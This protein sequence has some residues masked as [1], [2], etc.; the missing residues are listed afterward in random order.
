MNRFATIDPNPYPGFVPVKNGSSYYT[1]APDVPR[2]E[3][4]KLEKKLG[5]LPK[6]VEMQDE[7][8]RRLEMVP[9]EKIVN[10]FTFRIYD[11]QEFYIGVMF[12]VTTDDA[13]GDCGNYT[14]CLLPDYISLCDP[15]CDPQNTKLQNPTVHPFWN[16]LGRTIPPY[17]G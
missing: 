5:I 9:H 7:A 17:N 2:E 14:I 3:I 11:F 1:L 4:E 6:V 8:Q 13:D 15:Q 12:F 10:R 16:R